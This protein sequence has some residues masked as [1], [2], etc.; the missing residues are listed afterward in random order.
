MPQIKKRRYLR[1][2]NSKRTLPGFRKCDRCMC[3]CACVCVSS[4]LQIV[5]M[6][7]YENN[8]NCAVDKVAPKAVNVFYFRHILYLNMSSYYA[9]FILECFSNWM[10]EL[11]WVIFKKIPTFKFISLCMICFI[12]RFQMF[13]LKPTQKLISYQ[14]NCHIF[15][16]IIDFI[17]IIVCLCSLEIAQNELFNRS[18]N[19]GMHLRLSKKK[20]C[21]N[22]QPQIVCA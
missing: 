22:M 1:K 3:V 7:V 10:L 13:A 5:C 11:Q 8:N 16:V 15:F 9:K 18:D 21:S 14:K 20:I 2:L 12:L 17:I 19:N 6:N 4:L